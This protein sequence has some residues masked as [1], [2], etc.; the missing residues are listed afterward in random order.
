MMRRS[1]LF[2][3]AFLGIL[4][5]GLQ[6]Q[7][8]G[9]GEVLPAIPA[10]TVT[11]GNTTV[12]PSQVYRVPVPPP[13]ATSVFTNRT[14]P[15]NSTSAPYY[16]TMGGGNTVTGG[17][18][19]GANGNGSL[20]SSTSA[21]GSLPPVS[22]KL[23]G[24]PQNNQ[25]PYSVSNPAP[26]PGVETGCAAFPRGSADELNCEVESYK[27]SSM[28]RQFQLFVQRNRDQVQCGRYQ[29]VRQNK[30]NHTEVQVMDKFNAYVVGYRND[31]ILIPDDVDARVLW[32]S[33]DMV[34]QML[35]ACRQ[36]GL[37]TGWGEYLPP[38]TQ[39]AR[40]VGDYSVS[41]SN[42]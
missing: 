28:L 2:I 25:P 31:R 14:A 29:A 4:P 37:D 38:V 42:W 33:R 18:G 12:S 15:A 23:G 16:N 40:T 30:G 6:A 11:T 41:K 20:G 34:L 19:G 27:G 9:S 24:S 8:S 5:Q 10:R 13:G 21:H 3:V 17:N 26:V 39:R 35:Y 32:Q 22:G 1:W 36:Q 7:V